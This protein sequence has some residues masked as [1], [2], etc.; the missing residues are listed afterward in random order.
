MATRSEHL[1]AGTKVCPDCA[2]TIKAEAR[3]CRFCGY[4]FETTPQEA[5]PHRGIE[6]PVFQAPPGQD[7]RSTRRTI[8]YVGAVLLWLLFAYVLGVRIAGNGEGASSGGELISG[9]LA[10]VIFS[11]GIAAL[12]RL[13]YAKVRKRPFLS[14]WLFGLAAA[15]AWISYLGQISGE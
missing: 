3:V 4:R 10:A 13:I 8:A 7:T 14:P 9:L 2:E 15:L 12:A 1:E 6:E 5:N 11:L